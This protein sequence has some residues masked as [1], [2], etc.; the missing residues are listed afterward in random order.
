LINH[1]PHTTLHTPHSTHHTPHA[2]CS[3]FYYYFK[4]SF[5]GVEEKEHIS[6]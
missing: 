2:P 5:Q 6:E 4:S 3:A 1:T